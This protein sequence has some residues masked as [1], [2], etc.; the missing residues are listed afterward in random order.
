MAQLLGCCFALT[1]CGSPQPRRAVVVTCHPPVQP[2]PNCKRC[3]NLKATRTDSINRP[4]KQLMDV[5]GLGSRRRFDRVQVNW[6][7]ENLVMDVTMARS[8]EV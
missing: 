6:S 3:S 4:Q 8:S 1:Q 7:K 5:M 2:S